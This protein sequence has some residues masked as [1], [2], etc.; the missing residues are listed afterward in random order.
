MAA[1]ERLCETEEKKEWARRSRSEDPGLEVVDPHAAGV[2]VGNGPHSSP[3]GRTRPR[4]STP[5]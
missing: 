4:T 3:C 1:G 5:I 2:N